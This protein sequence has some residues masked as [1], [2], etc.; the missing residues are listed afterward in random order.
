MNRGGTAAAASV[1]TPADTPGTSSNG[2][3]AAPPISYKAPKQ[4]MNG[5]SSQGAT[6]IALVGNPNCGKTTLFNA[7]TGLRQRVGNYPGVTVERK[8]GTLVL[9]G[10]G[11][12]V[13]L[14]DLPG[15]YSLTPH[16]PD[17]RIARD[18]LLGF[19]S[20]TPRPDAIV[21]VVDTS[22]LERNLYLTSQILDLGLPVLI[23]LTMGDTA[24]QHGVRVD[25]SALERELGV[26]VREVVA[27]RRHGLPELVTAFTAL[28]TQAPPPARRWRLPAEAETEVSE[29]AALL[30]V[31]HGLPEPTAFSEALLLL[32]MGDGA[33][34]GVDPDLTRWY[35]EVRDHVRGDWERLRREGIDV[36]VAVAEARYADVGRIVGRTMRREEAVPVTLSEKL[37]RIF[38]HRF[39]GYPIF[40]ALMFIVFQAMFSWAGYP[41]DMISAGVDWLGQMA[42]RWLPEGDL[43][44]L[45]VNGIIGGVGNTIVFLPQIL[46]LFL[47]ISTLE[48]TGYLARAAVLMDRLMSRVGLHGKSF[49]PLLS[50]Y[51]CAIPGILATR[52]IES[53]RA[54]LITILVAPLMSCSARLPVYAVMI[55]AFLPSTLVAGFHVGPLTVGLTL[56]ALT[57]FALYALGTVAAFGMAALFNRTLLKGEPPSF[58]LEMPP[59][60]MPSLRTVLFQ[61]VERAWL[62]VK[63]AITVILAI[64]VVLWF[65]S[66]HPRQPAGASASDKIRHSY[67]GRLG[68]AMEPLIA[69]LGFDWKIGIGLISS[70]AAREVFVTA[71]GT[72]YNVSEDTAKDDAKLSL[73]VGDKMKADRNERTGRPT[74]TPLVAVALMVYYVLAMQCMSTIAVVRRETNGWKWPLFQVAYMT[75]L[76]WVVT[77]IVYQGGCLLGYE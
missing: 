57:L 34:G 27:S 7:L 70:F 5:S 41:A 30:K 52:T 58:L 11:R 67:A 23:V 14:I 74:F 25:A 64:S 46:L 10:D 29:L 4:P 12:T 2:K 54:R 53:P 3:T 18:V 51:A 36:S 68:Q 15:L 73:A 9:P 62:F 76:A 35:P 69:P 75:A 1:T 16:S 56:P 66:T 32:A 55:G 72:I 38:L 49:I 65:L 8:E 39:W 26:P 17:E 45:V 50:S 47:F 20:D 31:H 6:V 48:D 24:L 43:R 37:D 28:S 19:R 13:T 22:N 21:N 60:R 61:M 42:A 33:N 77:F 71:M 44:D 40:L 63:R 59:Y